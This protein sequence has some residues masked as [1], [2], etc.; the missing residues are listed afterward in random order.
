MFSRAKL[1]GLAAAFALLQATVSHAATLDWSFVAF[2]GLS[3]SGTFEADQDPMVL[4]NY[5]ITSATG[6]I[7]GEAVSLSDYDGASNL[8]FPTSPVLLLTSGV[9][10]VS[11][12]GKYYNIYEDFGNFEPDSPFFCGGVLQPYCIEGPNAYTES[13]LN[14]QALPTL[15]IS[16]RDSGG[17]VPEPATWAMLIVGF[18]VA[19]SMIRRRRVAAV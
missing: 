15:S 7:D 17:P 5:Q 16:L 11:V 4:T 10:F 12:S 6:F 2:N 1:F 8:V 9:G 19:G 14:V 13:G 18:G 3:G